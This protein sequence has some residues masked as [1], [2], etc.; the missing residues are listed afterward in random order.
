VIKSQKK[1]ACIIWGGYANGNT[2]DELCLAAALERKQREFD[3]NV[4]ILS[5]LPEYTLQIFPDATAIRYDSKWSR[6]RKRFIRACKC[7]T[8]PSGLAYL[9]RN[10]RFDHDPEWMRCLQGAGELYL[11]GGGYLT[12]VFPLDLIMPPVQYALKSNI[13]VATAPLGIGPFK[14][15]LHAENVTAALRRIT[16]KVRDQTSLDFCRARSVDAM[17]EPD[18]AVALLKNLFPAAPV[19]QR[20]ARPG[21]IGVNIFSQYGQDAGCDLTEWWTECLRGLKEQHPDY[22]IEGFCFHTSLQAEFEEM[23]RLFSRAGLPPRRV[24]APVVDFRRAAET[25][26][27]Y[28]LVISTRFHATLTANVFDIPNIA[29]AAGDYYQA[30]MSAA[31][32][33][34]EGACSVI[35]PAIQSP[36]DLLNI[37]NCKLEGRESGKSK[38]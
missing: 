3:G 33:G 7:V 16:L 8:A 20:G 34:Y 6:L 4:A 19:N 13:R 26:L 5:R 23:T 15:A 28:D 11:A 9:A 12:D 30:K 25:V 22:E 21:K 17:L 32:L 38:F 14:S 24:L 2:G 35:N 37:C 18:D 10:G 1:Y 27:N 31:R 29:I 36:E